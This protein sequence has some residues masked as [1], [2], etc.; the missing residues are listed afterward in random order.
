MAYQ[1]QIDCSTQATQWWI[2][3]KKRFNQLD[4]GADTVWYSDPSSHFSKEMNVCLAEMETI[5]TYGPS[6]NPITTDMYTDKRIADAIGNN[7]IV[8]STTHDTIS[9]GTTTEEIVGG[10][11]SSDFK[12]QEAVLM[13]Q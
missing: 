5:I 11:S 10:V 3:Q 9:S 4:G 1:R 6:G 7:V 8:Y 13:S 12:A 2:A